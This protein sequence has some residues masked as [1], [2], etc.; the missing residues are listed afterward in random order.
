VGLVA[1]SLAGEVRWRNRTFSN[2]GSVAVSPPD[3]LGLWNIL[4]TGETGSILRVNRFGNDEPPVTVG[5]WAM[6]RLCS[7]R[8]AGTSAPLLG[9]AANE[10]GELSA[11]G[12]S[13]SLKE[14]WNYPLPR[15]L[16]QKPIDP[17]VSSQILAG[18]GGEW[19]LAGPDGSIHVIT[20]DGRVFDSFYHG[21]AISGIAAGKL[22]GRPLLFVA[23]DDG[24][25][26]LEVSLPAASNRSREF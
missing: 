1:V 6:Q 17:V 13:G 21:A 11:V 8:F 22:G 25:A 15:G 4:V 19:W 26:A 10:K 23:T 12:L 5:Q 24:M 3:D 16:H 20:Q 7:G 9:L 14:A 2:A 18:H